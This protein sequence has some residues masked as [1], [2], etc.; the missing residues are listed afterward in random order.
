MKNKLYSAYLVLL[1]LLLLLFAS[2]CGNKNIGDETTQPLDRLIDGVLNQNTQ[3]YASAF[4]PDF[5]ERAEEVFSIIGSDVYAVLEETLKGAMDA[6]TVNF[7]DRV[8]INYALISKQKMSEEQL[9]EPYWNLY[10]DDYDL[11]VDK[12]TEAYVAQFDITVKGKDSEETKQAQYKLLLI[13]GTWYLH[14]ESFM[15]VFSI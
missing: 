12:I 2:G 15:N 7:G 1:V 8:R 11:P 4:S 6:H 9:N 3:T 13:D 10:V 5:I 14:P